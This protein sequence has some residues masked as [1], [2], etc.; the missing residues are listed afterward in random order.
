MAITKSAKKALKV[1]DTKRVYN[2]RLRKTLKSSVKSARASIA[3]KAA[4]TVETLRQAFKALDK[5]A[6]RGTIKA[7]NADR[8]KSRL[9]KLLA[10]NK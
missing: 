2:D 4:D 10:N 7:G 8:K 5:A 3:S 1:S 9:A 6:Q